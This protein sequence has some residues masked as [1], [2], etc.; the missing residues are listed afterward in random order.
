MSGED[1][2][3][4][5]RHQLVVLTLKSASHLPAPAPSYD[6][7]VRA[8][9]SG[10]TLLADPVTVTPSSSSSTTAQDLEEQQLVWEVSQSQ[11]REFRSR[12]ILLRVELW[13]QAESLGHF[14]VDLRT[15][16]ADR[17]KRDAGYLGYHGGY[18][19]GEATININTPHFWTVCL[20]SII[21]GA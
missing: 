21:D 12:K 17:K 7:V 18:L 11:L 13:I 6:L 20:M 16:G 8:E 19:G 15:A 9:L 10:V 14:V 1:S 3:R 2:D 5:S 4:S